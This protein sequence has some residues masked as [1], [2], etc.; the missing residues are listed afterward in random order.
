MTDETTETETTEIADETESNPNAEAAKYR[1]QLRD[2]EAERDALRDRLTQTR[3]SVVE[4]MAGLHKPQALWLSGIDVNDLFD[5]E[6]HADR[7]K[8]KAAV[9][10][11]SAS[12]GLTR[13][14]APDP[15]VGKN[16]FGTPPRRTIVDAFRRE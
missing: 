7:D 3:R 10:E 1:R 6:G 16:N 14:V 15:S 2:V 4:G 9:D 5:D 11:A 8:V 13:R 12:L